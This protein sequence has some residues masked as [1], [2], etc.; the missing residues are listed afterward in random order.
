MGIRQRL[1][2]L[3]AAS[4]AALAV[5]VALLMGYW[6][7]SSLLCGYD[8]DCEEVL[9]S[10]YGKIAG[11]PLPV[12][13]LLGFAAI[14]ACSLSSRPGS[15]PLLRFLALVAA[16]IG[17]TLLCVQFFVLH[18]ICPFCLVVDLCALVVGFTAF[19]WRP[20]TFAIDSGKARRLWLA[21]ALA[22]LAVGAAIGTARSWMPSDQMGTPPEVSA[23]WIPGKVTIVEA[24]DFQCPH[25][26]TMHQM[27]TQFLYLHGQNFHLVRV[28]SPME[29]HPQARDAARAYLCAEAENKGDEMAEL[30]FAANDL[31]PASCERLAESLGLSLP[32]FRACVASAEIERKIDVNVAWV[33]KACPQ[34]LPCIWVQDR[35]L[36]GEQTYKELTVALTTAELQL[37]AEDH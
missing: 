26:R 37:R 31:T 1:F 4:L 9:T 28:V 15:V 7:P 29:K 34:G 8:S 12:F 3:R 21:T 17:G 35:Q 5:S 22:S 27:L 25:C 32:K 23:H 2:I 30:L 19:R 13:G 6:R 16:V 24:V 36:L 20:G 33:T 11:V 10:Q 14:F 18:Q